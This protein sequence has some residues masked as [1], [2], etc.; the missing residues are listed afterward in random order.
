MAIHTVI[1]ARIKPVV[2]NA[3]GFP[4]C[5]AVSEHVHGAIGALSSRDEVRPTAII[6]RAVTAYALIYPARHLTNDGYGCAGRLCRSTF[7]L[8]EACLDE[9]DTLTARDGMPNAVLLARAID[10]YRL[11]YPGRDYRPTP[12]LR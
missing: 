8:T 4:L 3:A 1:T 10:A 11:M 9:I 5:V 12:V 7:W 2:A 6:T